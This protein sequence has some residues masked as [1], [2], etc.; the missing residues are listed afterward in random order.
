MCSI[1]CVAFC[2]QIYENNDIHYVKIS[3]YG[4]YELFLTF[5]IMN[6]GPHV[7]E[8]RFVKSVH[9][10]KNVYSLY[11]NTNVSVQNFS[12]GWTMLR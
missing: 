7:R 5:K 12:N 3:N 10:Q 8:T 2:R 6:S 4:F 9:V 1:I 11:P